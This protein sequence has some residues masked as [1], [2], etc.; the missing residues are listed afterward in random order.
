MALDASIANSYIK[1]SGLSLDLY[2]S[3]SARAPSATLE[4]LNRL[5]ALRSD[6]RKITNLVELP[7]SL[8]EAELL[9]ANYRATTAR[10]EAALAPAQ[11]RSQA[12]RK[13][14]FASLMRH[15]QGF[16]QRFGLEKAD[17]GYA[18]C[19]YRPIGFL[20]P[21]Q[22][23]SRLCPTLGKLD[24]ALKPLNSAK[25]L[26]DL[27]PFLSPLSLDT[28][29]SDYLLLEAKKRESGETQ[30]LITSGGR[31]RIVDLPHFDFAAEG[32]LPFT[33]LARP[34]EQIDESYRHEIADSNSL[35]AS[36][37][38][39]VGSC[40]NSA[41]LSDLSQAELEKLDTWILDAL[42]L[43]STK[44]L[45]SY[46]SY[47]AIRYRAFK[48]QKHKAEG[49]FENFRH[50]FLQLL[51]KD[52]RIL[53]PGK[54]TRTSLELRSPLIIDRLYSLMLQQDYLEDVHQFWLKI[55]PKMDTST[56]SKEN[57]G[58]A[59]KS[60]SKQCP[61]ALSDFLNQLQGFIRAQKSFHHS[62][63]EADLLETPM[64]AN[65]VKFLQDL[66]PSYLDTL[67]I[68]ARHDLVVSILSSCVSLN[69]ST[70]FQ[71]KKGTTK[72]EEVIIPQLNSIARDLI[73]EFTI[74]PLANGRR[75]CFLPAS[76]DRGL[77]DH[78]ARVEKDWKLFYVKPTETGFELEA[79]Q[80]N[81]KLFQ[82]GPDLQNL[83]LITNLSFEDYQQDNLPLEIIFGQVET[84]A[85][86]PQV[87]VFRR[88]LTELI[89]RICDGASDSKARVLSYDKVAGII[90]QDLLLSSSNLNILSSVEGQVLSGSRID[91]GIQELTLL[92]SKYRALEEFFWGKDFISSFTETDRDQL[93]DLYEIADF[94][95]RQ[96]RN[97]SPIY[98]S[99][100][101][102]PEQKITLLK[103]Y[104]RSKDLAAEKVRLSSSLVKILESTDDTIVR[105]YPGIYL[106]MLY[107]F[108]NL[109]NDALRS[110]KELPKALIDEVCD[111]AASVNSATQQDPENLLVLTNIFGAKSLDEKIRAM[112]RALEAELLAAEST[113][114][115]IP[116]GTFAAGTASDA[117]NYLLQDDIYLERF[118]KTRSSK[119]QPHFSSDK[120]SWQQM[121]HLQN[122]CPAIKADSEINASSRQDFRLK[123]LS[124]QEQTTTTLTK[125]HF[126]QDQA[127][128]AMKICSKCIDRT[129]ARLSYD[130]DSGGYWQILPAGDHIES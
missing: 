26:N 78:D 40:A 120:I 51:F 91:G 48:S 16:K 58:F 43:D 93:E 103:F 75:L 7:E 125:S 65:F 113:K 23:Y 122:S 119:A 15:A 64:Q 32:L 105:K 35:E 54:G 24:S 99:E 88:K 44:Q 38:R 46:L 82:Y 98:K 55:F 49:F 97:L 30:L 81:I 45:S 61:Q 57:Y 127:G 111:F 108:A 4:Y 69:Y 114:E 66:K 124:N 130:Q 94:S 36:L 126:Y 29:I 129:L 19:E 74:M 17:L 100:S 27:V 34:A 56:Y 80:K 62:R 41:R 107:D 52:Q 121:L 25:T 22:D 20:D 90:D 42:G 92:T 83:D 53:S 8:D 37:D 21:E 86:N 79:L 14:Y 123:R 109:L 59:S 11:L 110:D 95:L 76:S 118:A 112:S 101:L 33:D 5:A 89:L 18:D 31:D 77:V 70:Q 39:L 13:K 87:E 117:N 116:A 102:N 84:D 73:E 47:M 9:Q 67:S 115:R 28:K 63:E 50:N 2:N 71:K 12:E 85:A 60:L 1:D 106:R 104:S 72:T 3:L 96:R 6:P 128:E 68:P 10:L